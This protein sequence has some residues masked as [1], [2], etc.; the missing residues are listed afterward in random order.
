MR[1]EIKV[2]GEVRSLAAPVTLLA[3]LQTLNLPSLERG[4]AVC[5]N[6]EVVRRNAWPQTRINPDDE[7]E[8]VNAT[9][10]G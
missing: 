1:M 2:N 5:V 8:I 9:Q 4:L 3:Y 6:G 10:G 7:L